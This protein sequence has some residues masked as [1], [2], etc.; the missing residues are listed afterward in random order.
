M[1]PLRTGLAAARRARAVCTAGGGVQLL[2]PQPRSLPELSVGLAPQQSSAGLGNVGSCVC[3]ACS[4]PGCPPRAPCP[5]AVPPSRRAPAAAASAS[6][7]SSDAD[8][9]HAV[10]ATDMRQ[11]GT[12]GPRATALLQCGAVRYPG[13][14][15]CCRW[16]RFGCWVS[17]LVRSDLERSQLDERYSLPC[18]RT[19]GDCGGE[20]WRSNARFVH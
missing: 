14:V 17:D 4:L 6:P 7:Y 19:A 15:R 13:A 1:D 12:A 20:C 2:A 11:S 18:W 8:A 9:L 16:R 5:P 3:H 10:A